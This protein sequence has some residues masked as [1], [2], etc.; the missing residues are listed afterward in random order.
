MCRTQMGQRIGWQGL[1]S[2]DVNFDDERR[3]LQV[4]SRPLSVLEEGP[5]GVEVEGRSQLFEEISV[6][7]GV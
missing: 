2:R 5:S 1:V 3:E 6:A 4:V 7:C